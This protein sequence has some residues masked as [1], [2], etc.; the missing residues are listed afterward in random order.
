M[1]MQEQ[2]LRKELEKKSVVIDTREKSE[3]L[4]ENKYV[5][6]IEE[7]DP[8]YLAYLEQQEQKKKQHA[9]EQEEQKKRE[10]Q[11][12]EEPSVKRNVSDII[13][14]SKA[15]D[16]Y[17]LKRTPAKSALVNMYKGK[18]QVVLDFGNSKALKTKDDE[19]DLY[20]K[21]NNAD[22][23]KKV[24]KQAAEENFKRFKYAYGSTGNDYNQQVYRD[25]SQFTVSSDKKE[26]LTM[27]SLYLGESVQ[28]QP[29]KKGTKK[30]MNKQ[31]AMDKMTEILMKLD[32]N[33]ISMKS[34]RDI[35]RHARK[36]EKI[37]SMTCAY[38]RLL[39]DNPEYMAKL[40]N[41]DLNRDD[42]HDQQEELYLTKALKEVRKRLEL[43]RAI[44]EFYQNRKAIMQNDY[45]KSHHDSDFNIDPNNANSEEERALAE[46]LV[47]TYYL[48]RN[49][50]R[51]NGRRIV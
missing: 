2:N 7:M 49:M 10:Q 6:K 45:Y 24:E 38:D 47:N 9:Q 50:L 27:L 1:A 29:G 21:Y 40:I 51:I 48:G 18:R 28:D 32:V 20:E 25:L 15:I 33:D 41:N 22:Y 34:D 14:G 30:T 35:I 16:K 39:S 12:K 8:M 13:Y 42:N 43:L 11:K 26:N 36:L 19:S 23:I 46:Q 31:R 4:K 17:R 44:S 37:T 5:H 3:I